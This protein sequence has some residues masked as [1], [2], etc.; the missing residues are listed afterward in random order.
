MVGGEQ[1]LNE[2]NVKSP[3]VSD[4]EL[5]RYS[6]SHFG[7]ARATLNS[8]PEHVLQFTW[9]GFLRFGFVELF[10][11][12]MWSRRS[13]CRKG[14]TK[15]RGEQRNSVTYIDV[16]FCY[17]YWSTSFQMHIYVLNSQW[18]RWNFSNERKTNVFNALE[19]TADCDSNRVFE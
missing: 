15:E 16:L 17:L 7:F 1:C 19:F 3:R 10:L 4:W 12:G 5:L 6:A 11:I 9:N 8:S 2:C 13:A 14:E 18:T